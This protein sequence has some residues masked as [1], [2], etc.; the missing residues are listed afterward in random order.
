MLIL[1]GK[2][3]NVIYSQDG[4][5]YVESHSERLQVRPNLENLIEATRDLNRFLR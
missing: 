2:D 3:D 5:S 4:E 1:V